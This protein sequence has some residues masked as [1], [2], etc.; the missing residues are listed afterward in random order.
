M[1]ATR[2]CSNLY[3]ACSPAPPPSGTRKSPEEGAAA[4]AWLTPP[5]RAHRSPCPPWG[6]HSPE[7]RRGRHHGIDGRHRFLQAVLLGIDESGCQPGHFGSASPRNTFCPCGS[8]LTDFSQ[9]HKSVSPSLLPPP[10][11]HQKLATGANAG[12]PMTLPRGPVTSRYLP[13]WCAGVMSS[14]P[15]ST[16]VTSDTFLPAHCLLARAFSPAGQAK[17]HQAATPGCPHPT[18]AKR[19]P[20]KDRLPAPPGRPPQFTLNSQ[21]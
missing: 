4:G 21:C 3:L 20:W 7:D 12:S 11:C 13:A 1:T 10:C 19:I 2:G 18:E 8:A 16:A 17:E 15:D 9:A 6:T 5:G 14:P